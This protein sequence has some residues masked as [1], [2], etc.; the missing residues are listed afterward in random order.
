MAVLEETLLKKNNG[1]DVFAF[2]KRR[3]SFHIIRKG[4]C[5]VLRIFNA[6]T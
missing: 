2:G 1:Y 4:N 3:E 5:L 6:K